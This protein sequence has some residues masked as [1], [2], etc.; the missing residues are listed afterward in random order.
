MVIKERK[1]KLILLGILYL[2]LIIYPFGQV[3]RK[4]ISF[5]GVQFIINPL[6]IVAGLSILTH[7]LSFHKINRFY[8]IF[9]IFLLTALFSLTL[10]FK[11]FDI[12][13]FMGAT[14]LIRLFAYSTFFLLVYTCVSDSLISKRKLFMFLKLD[15]AVIALIG[16]FQYLLLPDVRFLKNMGWDDH[17]Y[18]I[19]GSFFDPTFIGILL[20][21]GVIIYSI[22]FIF[23][24]RNAFNLFMILF[25]FLSVI[26]TYARAAY[27]SIFFGFLYMFNLK[28]RLVLFFILSISFIGFLYLLP[29]RPSEGVNLA[30]IYSVVQK[31]ENY[32]ETLKIIR[33]EPLF[34]VGYNNICL[35]RIKYV[36]DLGY[37]SHSCNGSDNGLL[38]IF[39]TTGVVGFLIFLNFVRSLILD[40]KK[41]FYKDIFISSGIAL[42]I[43]SMF[44]NSLF[45]PWVLGYFAVVL[46]LTDSE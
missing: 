14:Y 8:V 39:A 10:S 5:L 29:K 22:I 44:V 38:L 18:R 16:W 20:V 32:V 2:F 41:S 24:N 11:E 28:K 7:I 45:Y 25:L 21:F 1:R 31:K 26:F 33:K 15:I 3:L 19:V 46:A 35:A 30:R 42:F 23:K 12:N 17:Y 36:G 27:L 40:T 6:D 37:P 13:I 43:H 34:G 4:T 9:K